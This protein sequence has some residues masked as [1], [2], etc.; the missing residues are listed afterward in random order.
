MSGAGLRLDGLYKRFGDLVAVRDLSLH[1]PAGSVLTLLG[2]RGSGKTT[3]VRLIAGLD[4]P[5]AGRVIVGNED[6]TP[7][8][9]ADRRCSLVFPPDTLFPHL[10]VGENVAFGLDRTLGPQERRERVAESL[11]LVNLTGSERRRIGEL[12]GGEQQRV[13]VARAVAPQPRVLLFDEPLASVDPTLRERTRKDLRATI[14]HIG[15]TTVFVTEEQDE[16]FALGD[17]VAVLRQGGLEQ[18]ASP[19]ELY[20]K[21]ATVFVATFVGRATTLPGVMADID[22]VR[23]AT[24]VEWPATSP[25]ALTAGERV[26]VAVRPEM[27]NISE[28][29]GLR[30]TVRERR[31]TGARAFF[32]IDTELGSVEL[33][34]SVHAAE[35]GDTVWLAARSAIAFLE[36]RWR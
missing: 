11:A 1:V 13:A 20:E 34:A 31:Y 16:A 28:D 23:V 32:Q 25:V 7:L 9:P 29:A 15:A 17:P 4:R 10:D 21:P 35:I 26:V 18:L 24:G 3:T 2:P 8:G 27:L 14:D 19:T 5:D 6:V 12:S 36:Q 22:R 33:E 30:G